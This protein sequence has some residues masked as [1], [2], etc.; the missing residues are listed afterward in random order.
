MNSADELRN[1]YLTMASIIDPAEIIVQE[2]ISGGGKNL[3]S[4]AA[5]FDGE[6]IIAGMV[7]NRLRQ[8]PREFG[9]A[10]TF[11][12]SVDIP[13]LKDLAERLLQEIGFCGI[14]EIEFMKDERDAVYKFIEINGRLWGWHTLAKAAGVNLPLLL[15]QHSNGQTLR[16]ALAKTGIKWVRL[17]TDVP[18]CVKD[19]LA[20][21]LTFKDYW[22]SMSGRKEFACSFPQRSSPFFYGILPHPLLVEKAWILMNKKVGSHVDILYP[23]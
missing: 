11:A 5:L 9:H 20:G 22:W 10:T 13:E 4:Y 1:E 2:F 6:K 21:Y 19:I 23:R 15:Y 17:I 3:Y 8:H 16:P 18:T 12:V 14:A 7:A